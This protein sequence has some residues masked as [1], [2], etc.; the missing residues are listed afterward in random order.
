[1]VAT[2]SP[3]GVTR[4]CRGITKPKVFLRSS[5][6][7]AVQ[8]NLTA[9]VT[10]ERRAEERRGFSVSRASSAV[11]INLTAEVTEERRA[12][13]RRGFS[14]SSASSAIQINLTAEVTEERKGEERE[15]SLCPLRPQRLESVHCASLNVL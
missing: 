1:M 2:I 7:S 14:V 12:E 13:E 3:N 10:E 8:I 5:A 15:G 6:S 11:Q 9:E 4:F